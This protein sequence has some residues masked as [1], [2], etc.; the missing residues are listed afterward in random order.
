M[1][2]WMHIKKVVVIGTI[3]HIT[4]GISVYNISPVIPTIIAQEWTAWTA[5]AGEASG[6]IITR[7]VIEIMIMMMNKATVHA[8]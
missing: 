4:F 8:L 1:K 6:G 7:F 5:S 3:P 2:W